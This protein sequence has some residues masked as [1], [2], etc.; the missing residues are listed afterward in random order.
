MQQIS[1]NYLDRI[2]MNIQ[3][4]AADKPAKNQPAKQI[5]N[6]PEVTPDFNVNVPV[7]YQKIK[8]INL[9]YDLKGHC[10]KL[11]NGQN[12]I[13]IPKEGTTVVKSYVKTG[14]LSIIC[15]MVQKDLKKVNFLPALTKW[16][17][18]VMLQPALQKLTT[19]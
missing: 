3:T 8:D 2:K 16:E 7:K 4:Q 6:L 9:P 14:S 1:T 19:I 17:P 13:I 18:Q 11:S 5:D 15:L 12:V 10:Y